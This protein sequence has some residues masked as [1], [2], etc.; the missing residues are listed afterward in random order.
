MFRIRTLSFKNYI[1]SLLKAVR[2]L[3]NKLQVKLYVLPES[4]KAVHE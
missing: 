2:S 1:Q 3:L 4:N